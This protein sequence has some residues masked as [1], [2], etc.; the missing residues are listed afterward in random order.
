MELWTVLV[1]L[2]KVVAYIL[3]LLMVGTGLFILHF[4]SMLSPSTFT[5]CQKLIFQSSLAGLIVAPLLFLLVAG[6][7]GGDIASSIDPLMISIAFSSKAGQAVLVLFL[8]FLLVCFWSYILPKQ[9]WTV[10]L[11]GF[12]LIL[13]SFSVYGHSTINGYSTQLL[14][15]LHLLAISYWVGSFLPLRYS[16]YRDIE[17]EKLFQIAHKFGIYA[18]Y[19]I[20]V[21]V[22]AGVSLGTVLVG[23]LNGLLYTN[24]GQVFLIKLSLVTILLG[25]GAMNK[26]FLVPNLQSDAKAYAVKLRKSIGREIIILAFILVISSIISTTI[27]PPY[28]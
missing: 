1:P 5:Y 21:L 2:G 11:A 25:I 26:F 8:G 14:I 12:S 16:T 10:A 20:V 4:Q 9:I 15:V 18:V 17:D 6:N 23:D 3:S 13:I 19:Y 22:I 24:Y 28:K 7:I 27:E